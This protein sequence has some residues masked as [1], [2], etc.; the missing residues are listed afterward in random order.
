MTNKSEENMENEE[1]MRSKLSQK[2]KGK[3]LT[4]QCKHEHCHATFRIPIVN[5]QLNQQK[6]LTCTCGRLL[7]IPSLTM[8]SFNL[9]NIKNG[10]YRV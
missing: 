6:S 10:I 1:E 7:H 3:T 8:V 4:L 5:L 9:E 2:V